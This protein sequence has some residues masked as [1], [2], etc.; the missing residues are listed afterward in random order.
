VLIAWDNGSL[1]LTTEELITDAAALVS[2]T[3]QAARAIS[4]ARLAED[5]E[6]QELL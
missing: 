2:G 5:R 4:R 1:E 6:R 3:G